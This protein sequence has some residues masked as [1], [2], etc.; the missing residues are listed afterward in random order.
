MPIHADPFDAGSVGLSLG[1]HGADGVA[2][3]GQRRHDMAA[4]APARACDKDPSLCLHGNDPR[5]SYV[6]PA[7]RMRDS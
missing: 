6:R 7:Q 3:R 4:D 2:G 5:K 1:R